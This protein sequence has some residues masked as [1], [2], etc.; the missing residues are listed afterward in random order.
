MTYII[1]ELSNQW[2]GSLSVLNSMLLQSAFSGADAAKIQLFGDDW[3]LKRVNAYGHDYL[4][5]S[6]EN[7]L[8]FCNLCASFGLVSIASP[9]DETRLSWVLEQNDSI[10]KIGYGV[11]RDR[12]HISDQAV[13]SGHRVIVSLDP[14]NEDIK[15][16]PY[17][18][19]EN[20][21]YLLTSRKYPTLL[22]DCYMPLD[23]HDSIFDGYSD[24]CPGIAACLLA[25]SRGA[26]LLEK[27]FSFSK[28]WQKTGEMAHFGSATCDELHHL[29]ALERDLRLIGS[30]SHTHF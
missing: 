20:V 30:K 10:I 3:N 26:S 23:F 18:S 16:K 2:G 25:V 7:Y 28:T 22:E 19:S 11:F 6:Y 5:V 14:S 12:R 17:G 29:R 1:S 9:L 8:S 4:S 13:E 21:R 24:H 15:Q 27:H